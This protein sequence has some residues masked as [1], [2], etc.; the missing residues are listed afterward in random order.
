MK[1]KASVQMDGNYKIIIEVLIAI[2]IQTRFLL[3]MHEKYVHLIRF[4]LK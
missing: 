2:D 4:P 1:S 3:F